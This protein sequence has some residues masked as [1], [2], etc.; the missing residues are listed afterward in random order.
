MTPVFESENHRRLHEELKQR[1]LSRVRG[2]GTFTTGIDGLTISARELAPG[3]VCSCYTPSM[4]LILCGEKRSVCGTR[5]YHYGEGKLLVT[6]VDIPSSFEIVERTVS[7]VL[8]IDPT[9]MSELVAQMPAEAFDSAAGRQPVQAFSVGNCS[10]RMTEAMLRLFSLLDAPRETTLR[11][12]GLIR[13]IYC[14]LL[15]EGQGADIRSLYTKGS[16]FNR[17]TQAILWLRDNYKESFRVEELAN[18]VHMST[19]SFHRHFKEVTSIS[20]LQYH[21]RLRLQEA[22]RLLI[23]EGIDV[24]T[25]AYSV[26]YESPAQFSREYKA[27]FGL[28]PRKDADSKRGMA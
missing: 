1:V 11:A 16:S 3:Q 23:A 2:N 26:G 7:I 25:A 20:P 22:Q 27:L 14:L 19:S 10:E 21:K 13:D 9:L 18:R 15:L 17:I 6:G 12:P 24:G 8:K 5:V 4:G 28:P